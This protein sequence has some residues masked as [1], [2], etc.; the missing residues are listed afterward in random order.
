MKEIVAN[1]DLV[2]YCGLYCGACGSYLKGRCPGCHEN[3]KATWCKIRS[4]CMES[5][6]LSCADCKEHGDPNQCRHFNNIFSKVAALI[7][8]SNRAACICKIRELGIDGFA[9]HMAENKKQTMPRRG[10]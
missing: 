3:T 6:F 5:S 1:K 10:T 8:N 7:F 9:E 4:C 2:A